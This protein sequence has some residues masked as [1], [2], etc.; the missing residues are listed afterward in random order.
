MKT[1]QNV[2]ASAGSPHTMEFLGHAGHR[3]SQKMFPRLSAEQIARLDAVGQRRRVDR[4]EILVEQGSVAPAFFV[5]I[6]GELAMVY[7]KDGR[8]VGNQVGSSGELPWAELD[9]TA[10]HHD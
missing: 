2:M 10:F 6:S 7:P 8:E 4:G 5:V 3:A 9:R 1:W